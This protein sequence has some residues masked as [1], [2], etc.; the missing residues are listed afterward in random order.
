MIERFATSP[1][2]RRP[3]STAH[4]SAQERLRHKR[5]DLLGSEAK[6]TKAD[7]WKLLRALTEARD[8]YA[9]SHRTI[10]VLEALASF[11]PDHLM[12]GGEP[13]IVFPSNIELSLRTRGMSPAT[14]RRHIAALVDGGFIMRRDSPNGK[15]YVRRDDLGDVAEAYGF[16]LSPFILRAGEIEEHAAVL[17]QHL[18]QVH[19]VRS[20]ITIHLR[21]ISK[22]IDAGLSEER[23]GD[24]ETL[25]DRLAALSGKV[26]RNGLLIDLQKRCDA[27][28]SLRKDVETAYLSV[29]S[30]QELSG[31]E[32]QIERHIQ[33]SNLESNIK[34]S[35]ENKMKPMANALPLDTNERKKGA[36]KEMQKRWRSL[37]EAKTTTTPTIAH[38]SKTND[39][40]VTARAVSLEQILAWCP[41]IESFSIN[42]IKNWCDLIDVAAFVRSM[43]GI[44]SD[45]WELAKQAMGAVD[46]AITLAAILERASEIRSPGGYLRALTDRAQL[47]R[48]SVQPV[49][50]A[51]DRVVQ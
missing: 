14:L 45:A 48:Y 4:F 34:T 42:E 36:L 39:R 35:K 31:N 43:L 27:L 51:L 40:H 17:R 9:L 23:A 49:L 7:R 5:E 29:L 21:D 19:A 13:L 16:D 46:A 1:F 28:S 41:Q 47:G 3:L 12:D 50:K 44:S 20:A 11:H 10:A 15:R 33:N 32:V 25:A 2:G 24:W 26:A 22:T 30:E 18:R 38:V 6:S 8:S 37:E